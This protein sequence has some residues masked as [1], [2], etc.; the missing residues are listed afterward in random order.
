MK[1]K[2]VFI[3][4]K[5][6]IEREVNTK[7]V[8]EEKVYYKLQPFPFSIFEKESELPIDL[9]LCLFDLKKKQYLAFYQDGKQLGLNEI[10]A[11]NIK[12]YLQ[13]FKIAELTKQLSLQKPEGFEKYLPL[14]TL[15]SILILILF[16]Y[17]MIKDVVNSL[18][19]RFDALNKS[20]QI[21][22]KN[23]EIFINITKTF[24][25]KIGSLGR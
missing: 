11:L 2:I 13:N 6:L 8:K 7:K 3:N 25:N 12:D 18:N 14:I 23:Q 24:N 21:M 15:V 17:Y 5:G 20:I 22:E 1:L 9:N 16:S 19:A 4:E 10:K